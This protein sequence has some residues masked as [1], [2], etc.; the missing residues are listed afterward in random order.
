M[1][2]LR[3]LAREDYIVNAINGCSIKKNFP[4]F[5]RLMFN[6]LRFRNVIAQKDV[7]R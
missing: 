5:A 7:D 1:K 3:I 4:E 2:T 6:L